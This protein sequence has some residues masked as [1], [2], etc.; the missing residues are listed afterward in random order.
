MVARPS[1]PVR[2]ANAGEFSQSAKGR[3][4][5]K[6]YYSAGLAYKN[7][8]PV[9]Q[10]GFRRMGGTWRKGLWR[11]PLV[12]LA[13][14]S[15]S[16][17]AGPHTGTATIWTGTVA[18]NV[19]AVLAS[20]L[21]VSAGVVT[22]TI[23]ALVSGVWTAVGGPFAVAGATTRLAAFAPGGQKAATSLRI[24]AT[25]SESATVSG[26][27]VTAFSE[28][29]APSRPRHVQLTTD[30]GDAISCFVAA[31]IADFFTSDGYQGAA[32]LA[33]VTAAML[34]DLGFYAEADTIL[35]FHGELET[36]RLVHVTPDQL[37]DWRADLW[38][39][40][41]KPKV[42]L[43]GTYAKTDDIWE[44]MLRWSADQLMTI[45]VTV[46]GEVTPGI[47]LVDNLG[48]PLGTDSATETDW[49]TFAA[50]V[51]DAIEALPTIGPTVTIT[52][53]GASSGNGYRRLVVTFGGDL[54][55]EEYDVSALVVNTADVSALAYHTQVGKTDFEDLMSATRGWPGG[56]GLVQDRMEY[57]RFPALTAAL[58]Q[59]RI[60][61]YADLDIAATGDEAARLDK[62][63][64]QTSETILHVV[65]SN[66][67]FAFT[68]RA[69]YFVPNRT[70]ER[71]TPL[72]FV[73]CSEIGAQPNCLPFELE[74]GLHYVAIAEKG[75]KDY[76]AGGNQLLRL[77]ESAVTS[78]TSFDANPVSLL[79]S[80]LVAGVVRDARQKAQTDLD[81]SRGWQMRADGRLVCG[82]FIRNQDITGF[83]E[84]VA[85]SAG[86]VREIGVDG[87]NALWLS[88][89]RGPT[90]THELYDPD[91]FLQDA[92]EASA[93]LAGVVTGLPYEDGAVLWAVADGYVLG[94][95]TCAT[96][97]I[98]LR[99]SYSD[100]VV[101]RWTAPRW[102]S[103]PQVYVTGGDE[104]IWR[105]G[106]IHTL[107]LNVI[108]TTSL[109]VGAN[110]EAPVPVTL[111][112]I[113]DPV[114]QPM[115]AKTRLVTVS[116]DDLPGYMVGAT[117]VV[118][119]TRP[120]ELYVRDIAIGA[121]L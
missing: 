27:T 98:D 49:D 92:V 101:G 29:G 72:D 90:G 17:D 89:M 34:P 20:A 81:A 23:E 2:S 83:C 57:W 53:N 119:Q 14:A 109:A 104:V 4:D 64:T 5:I 115:P 40:G 46:N 88:I 19:A 32:R 37:A 56:A 22:F 75:L 54:S 111:A 24:R 120:G 80:H 69:V 51:K 42:D 36:A 38:P 121:K 112:E 59:S 6:Q 99:D 103:M 43:G 11:K 113:G 74:G 9:P 77:D 15:P 58:A 62:L 10:G 105:P 117:A 13:I 94:P 73:K 3:V 114:D 50:A 65:E 110:G 33:N 25:F 1:N 45:N 102:E 67:L 39:Y 60:G 61:E 71:N 28:S 68:D 18:G 118:T 78:S 79:A 52:H 91:I 31:G 47:A 8:E 82:Q 93:D 95:F 76:A 55:G 44:I 63:R 21:A 16:L 41:E 108:D 100:I 85:A 7:I 116:G 86:L 30:E 107:A 97:A 87:E 35:I 66:Y 96:G 70:I 84:W 106:R 26:L 12:S 48:N